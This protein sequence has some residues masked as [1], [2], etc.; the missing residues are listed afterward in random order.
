MDSGPLIA[1]AAIGVVPGES[2]ESLSARVLSV[3]HVIYP[4]ALQLVASGAVVVEN[5]RVKYGD[6]L[7]DPRQP[8]SGSDWLIVPCA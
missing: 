1:Q 6:K 8:P 3:E 4:Y 2:E 5:D 7:P